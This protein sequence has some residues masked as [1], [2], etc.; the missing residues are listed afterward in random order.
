[1]NVDDAAIAGL[2]QQ[3]AEAWNRGDGEAFGAAFEEDA[4]YVVFNGIHLKGRRQIADVHQQLFETA[5]KG[6]RLV[7]GSEAPPI[8][9]L[10]PH[11]AL[12]HSHGRLQR[13]GESRESFGQDSVQT[14]VLVKRGERWLIAAFQ[15]T[16]VQFDGPPGGG[17][18]S[19]EQA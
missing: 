8:R 17:P 15:N 12:V 19:R 11:V 7:G 10:C 1:M 5:L 9:F 14:F 13:P 16:R 2:F 6:T 3:L 18:P 4:D